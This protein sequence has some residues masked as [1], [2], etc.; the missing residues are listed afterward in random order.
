MSIDASKRAAMKLGYAV[1]AIVYE[2]SGGQYFLGSKGQGYGKP[3]TVFKAINSQ[4]IIIRKNTSERTARTLAKRLA[5][6]DL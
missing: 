2:G 5:G 1:T 6:I 4:A 3:F